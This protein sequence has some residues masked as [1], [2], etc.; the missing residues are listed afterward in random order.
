MVM[1]ISVAC[2][3]FVGFLFCIFSGFVYSCCVY[4]C[5]L[6]P[7]S[8]CVSVYPVLTVYSCLYCVFLFVGDYFWFL[9]YFD[10]WFS[11]LSCP[12]TSCVFPPWLIVLPR[13]DVF[14]LLSHLFLVY[15][16]P[17]VFSLCVPFVSC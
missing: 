4:F 1:D 14:H 11:V 7:C 15:S 12:L 6:F 10:V 2:F 5:S 16:L 9:F 17:H 8:L 3:C 13:P